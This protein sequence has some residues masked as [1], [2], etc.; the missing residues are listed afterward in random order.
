[1]LR[2][3]ILL[4]SVQ[5]LRVTEERTGKQRVILLRQ[6]WVDSRCFKDAYVHVIG[7]FSYDDT[8]IIDD[9]HNLLILHPDFLISATVVADSFTCTR[10]AVLQDRVKATGGA[11]GAQIYGHILH[12]VLQEA[13]TADRWDVDW[14][15]EKGQHVLLKYVEGIYEAG[16]DLGEASAHLQSKMPLLRTWAEIF[17]ND[18]P[19]PAAVPKDGRGA[20]NIAIKRLIEV[21]E[22]VWSPMYGLKGNIDAT[23]ELEVLEQGS[24]KTLLVPLELKTGKN[25]SVAMHRAQTTLYTFLLSDRYDID[26]LYGLLYYLESTETFRV[27]SVR[28][29]LRG[30]IIQRNE[31]AGYIRERL[32]LPPMLKN[33]RMCGSCYAQESCFI[34]HRIMDDGTEETSDMGDVF[35]KA[36]KQLK[37][38]HHEF[39][40][41]WDGLIT[42]EEKDMLKFRRE[43][44]TMT[45]PERQKLGRCFSGVVID[46]DSVSEPEPTLASKINRFQYTFFKSGPKSDF[47]FLD[48]QMSVGEPIVISDEM[49][50]FALS[51]GYITH[52]YRHKVVVAVDRKLQ[53]ARLRRKGFNPV[54]NQ[55]FSGITT[56]LEKGVSIEDHFKKPDDPIVYRIDKDEFSNGMA[57]VR[58]NL[59][60]VMSNSVEGNQRAR[61]LVVDLRPPRFGPPDYVSKDDS[62]NED[63]KKAIDTVMR[64]KD[65]ALVLGMP[66]TGKTTTIA[67]IIRALVS[68]GKSVLLTSY[69]HTAV[70]NILLK[71][72]SDELPILRLGAFNKIHPDVREFAML[73]C[74]SRDSIEGV[75][76]MYT[77][78]M[79]VA[80]TCLGINH[81]IFNERTFDYCIVDEASQ[82]TLP[83]C[84]GP[85]RMAKK[86]VLV[87]DHNQLPP[88]VRDKEALKGGL[89]VSLF[90]LLSETHPA[91]VTSLRFQ[92]RM[93]KEI[94]VLSNTLIY[95]GQ[96]KC[97]TEAVANREMHIPNMDELALYHTLNLSLADQR[98]PSC[99]GSDQACWLRRMVCPTTKVCFLNTDDL[100]AGQITN[101][102]TVVNP[103]EAQL[104]AQLV[105]AFLTTGVEPDDIGI[106]T[107]Y[108]A[109]LSLL[110][111]CMRH[112]S[113]AVEMH[114]ADRFQG[115]DKECVIISLVRNNAEQIIGDLLQDW[116]RINV[117]F[118]RARTKLLIIGSMATLSG[119]ELLSKFFDIMRE[120]DWIYQL[121]MNALEMHT[122]ESMNLTNLSM[123]STAGAATRSKHA[124]DSS[125]VQKGPMVSTIGKKGIL[126][127]RPILKDIL[128]DLE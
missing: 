68:K 37:P 43:L 115:R 21:E 55:S 69:T 66:G 45:S 52:L 4:I 25:T 38:N 100:G 41:K 97:G 22:H 77:T 124:P 27:H 61:E 57:T 90:K 5:I 106:I 12:E 72:R 42:L 113:K 36:I 11:N 95:N 73:G 65:Y 70:D 108:R 60:Q 109:Q 89:D 2:R 91:A 35:T 39:F 84:L 75:R 10:R 19:H 30:M 127:G 56:K 99:T 125:V 26:V 13:L 98:S 76:E 82:I 80:T 74:Q 28:N 116:R 34:D 63:Q 20:A 23:V 111:D 92:Y 93:C 121:P 71:L 122:F 102:V 17:V 32:A 112:V 79:V 118:T 114:T 87:G 8:C 31:L 103:T 51:N 54:L 94:M 7:N 83:V 49:G 104:V 128:K 48:S 101:G 24:T 44:W 59:V 46:S 62:M 58:N 78:P 96:L 15:V 117:A 67:Q 3:S 1:L 6:S 105:D 86:F 64:A 14:L 123:A 126:N 40:K 81:G 33:K 50:H 16:L 47:S 120:N 53:N 29:E 18:K 107:P 9:K 110:K 88:L 119:N 85:I